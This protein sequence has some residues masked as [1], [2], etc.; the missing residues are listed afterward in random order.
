MS[1]IQ[2][3]Y[4]RRLRSVESNNIVVTW[5]KTRPLESYLAECRNADREGLD[6]CFR[7]PSRPAVSEGDRCYIVHSGFIRGW[8]K[9]LGVEERDDVRDPITR[10]LME[11]GF[12][13]R[14]DPRWHP[15][16]LVRMRGFQGYRYAK[17]TW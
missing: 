10:E 16:R 15:C 11:V 7:V 5:P 3:N 6:I 4:G 17:E 13:V 2:T 8:Q 1:E 9:V 14:R 12:Y